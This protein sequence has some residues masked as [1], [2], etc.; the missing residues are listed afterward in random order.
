M[1]EAEISEFDV[2]VIFWLAEKDVFWEGGRE[3]GREGSVEWKR[4][5]KCVSTH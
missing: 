5:G 3:G 2:H 1:G 4:K